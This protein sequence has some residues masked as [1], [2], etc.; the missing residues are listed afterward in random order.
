MISKTKSYASSPSLSIISQNPNHYQKGKNHLLLSSAR[1]AW[2]SLS[3]HI[4]WEGLN[5][6][7]GKKLLKDLSTWGIGG[8]CVHFLQ[9]FTHSQLLSA[10]RYCREHSIPFIIVGK[11]SNCLFDDL[12]YDGCVIQNRIEFL[13]M[14]EPGIYR[15]G[16][17]FP[18]NRLGVQ[19][20]SEEYTGLE[21]AGGIPGT[22]GG[23]VYMNA[24]ANGQ[25]TAG[26]VHGVEFVTTEGKFQSL[27]RTDLKF[28]YRSSPFQNMKNLAAIV[29][30]TFQL[31]HSASARRMQRQYLERRRL[32]QPVGEQSAGSVFRNPSNLGVTAGELIER[33]GL[34]GYRVGGAMVSSIHANFFVNSGQSTSQD[35]LELIRL[36]KEKVYQRFGVQLKEEVLYVYPHGNV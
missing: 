13:E 7:R 20:S 11:G 5:V 12:G 4:K 28:G 16:S 14:N 25:E 34:K 18:F 15:A 22:V 8:P 3:N 27:Y 33:A 24:G 36:V 30:V 17:G 29:A 32:S 9:V 26:V 2:P 21:F 10:L 1:K 35:M 19:C 31:K 23:A 6:I